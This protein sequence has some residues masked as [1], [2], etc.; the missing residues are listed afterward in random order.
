MYDVWLYFNAK[1]L[2]ELPLTA[3]QPLIVTI[4]YYWGVGLTSTATQFFTYYFIIF[5]II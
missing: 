5:A 2:T 1:T 3:L 4:I